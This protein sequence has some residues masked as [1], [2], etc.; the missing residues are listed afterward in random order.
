M[1]ISEEPQKLFFNSKT[2]ICLNFMHLQQTS[3]TA[4]HGNS[5]HKHYHKNVAD[6]TPCIYTPV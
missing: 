6:L 2:K 3:I 5:T 1:L 4:L